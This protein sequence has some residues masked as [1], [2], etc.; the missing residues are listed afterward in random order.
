M[1]RS[2]WIAL[3][4]AALAVALAT[5]GTAAGASRHHGGGTYT[6][7]PLVSDQAGAAAKVDPNLVNGWGISAGPVARRRP[8]GCPTTAPT[9]RRSTTGQATSC[10]AAARRQGARRSRRA[11]SSTAERVPGPERNGDRSANVPAK[12][13]FATQAGTIQGW[14]P[15]TTSTVTGF[16]GSKWRAVYTGLAI[17]GEWLYAADFPNGRVDIIDST[18]KQVKKPGAFTDCEAAQGLLAVRDPEPRRVHLRHS[19]R[20]S[21]PRPVTRVHGRGLGIVDEYSHRR[22]ARGPRRNGRQAERSVGSR[23]GARHG[24]RQGLRRAARRQLRRRPTSTRSARTTRDAGSGP[25]DC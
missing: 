4:G 25:D 23:L 8:G 10:A 11:R 24:L 20:C 6:V 9:P 12:F 3:A 16:D 2:K 19:T 18:W 13:M 21:I 22:R 5:A 1:K 14:P 7:T 15:G 17:S